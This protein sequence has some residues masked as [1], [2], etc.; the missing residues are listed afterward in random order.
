MSLELYEINSAHH[1]MKPKILFIHL[2]S[3]TTSLSLTILY[4]THHYSSCYLTFTD[5]LTTKQII[6][7]KG[8]KTP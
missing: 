5:S 6:Y 1:R 8:L 2:L 4:L 7:I 3:Y